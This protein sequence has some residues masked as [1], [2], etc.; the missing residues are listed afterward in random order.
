M[1]WPFVHVNFFNTGKSIKEQIRV[2]YIVIISI[3]ILP[4]LCSLAIT[5]VHTYRYDRIITNV[6]RANELNQTVK[7]EIS[8]EVWDIVAGKKTFDEGNQ[9][10]ILARIKDGITEMMLNTKQ[11]KNLQLLE[12]A[13][14]AAHTL[15]RNVDRLGLQ[16]KNGASVSDTEKTLEDIRGV[17]SLI[18]DILQDFIVAEIEGAAQTNESIKRLSL[19]LSLLQIVVAAC[20]AFFAYFT[21]S[22]VSE[23]IRKPIYELEQLSYSIASGNLAAR[24]RVPDVAELDNLTNN[25]NIMAGKIQDLIAENIREQQNLKKAEMKTLQAQITPHF[26]YNTLDTII[27]LAEAGKTSDVI[28][29][30]RALSRFF[31][32][33]LSR[34]HEW[35]TVA[36]EMEHVESYLFIQKIR[37]R[38]ILDYEVTYDPSM[39]GLPALKLVLQPLVENAI[40]HGLKNR[41]E[42]G[43]LII[44]G[45]VNGSRMYFSVSDNGIGMTQE[46]LA[47]VKAEIEGSSRSEDLASVYGLYNVSKRLKL[48]YNYDVQFEIESTY[49]SGTVVRLSMPVDGGP[50]TQLFGDVDA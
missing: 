33:S 6:S 16:T 46:R 26:L 30:T 13:A 11:E 19:I 41:R 18:Y 9:Y 5:R 29:I 25:L 36:Q 7:I 48:Y 12:V 21:L 37:Y 45:H 39:S 8:D 44:E 50:E 40:Y 24:A 15:E 32:I 3:M 42:R 1:S 23:H 47:Q 49:R 27:W 20:V 35:I 38:D 14:R 43:K 22:S 4:T 34:G 17:A 10:Q 31:R 2:S 28:E